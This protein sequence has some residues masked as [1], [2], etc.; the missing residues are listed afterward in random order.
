MIN[1]NKNTEEID[2]KEIMKYPVKQLHSA[3]LSKEELLKSMFNEIAGKL[4]EFE[5]LSEED[6]YN[7]IELYMCYAVTREN[8]TD[9]VQ[10]PDISLK[11]NI[12]NDMWVPNIYLSLK[13][14]DIKDLM[15][16]LWH[17]EYE[18]A[19]IKETRALNP[20]KTDKVG[21][22]QEIDANTE[23]SEE[24]TTDFFLHW[25]DGLT[26]IDF[27]H[28]HFPHE[29]RAR[30]TCLKKIT[31]LHDEMER[32]H[33]V[34]KTGRNNPKLQKE[35]LLINGA[36]NAIQWVN[37]YYKAYNIKNTRFFL[38]NLRKEEKQIRQKFHDIIAP[39][40]TDDLISVRKNGDLSNLAQGLKHRNFYDVKVADKIY[41]NALKCDE[42]KACLTILNLLDYPVDE[43][44]IK[45]LIMKYDDNKHFCQ[46]YFEMM[47]NFHD[48]YLAGLYLDAW[49]EKFK[50]QNRCFEKPTRVKETPEMSS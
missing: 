15:K 19:H 29:K 17:I 30:E 16:R 8:L 33:D 37:E 11:T 35:A 49:H 13:N 18:I 28:F 24:D 23:I 34:E 27:F 45:D 3:I 44:Q 40:N 1:F 50:S 42:Y 25:K 38:E 2:E 20:Y 32:I 5:T 4:L 14:K 46:D 10:T 47:T 21:N 43:K 41:N 9:V 39:E 26:F 36:K 22:I 6:Q 12:R 7:L 31:E 48:E